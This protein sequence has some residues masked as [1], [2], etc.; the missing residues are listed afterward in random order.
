[1][2]VA[3]VLIDKQ[4]ISRNPGAIPT[5]LHQVKAG[6]D[7]FGLTTANLSVKARAYLSSLGLPDPD[8]SLSIGEA[9]WMH[10]LAIAYS[11]AYVSQNADGLRQ[12]WP[13]VPLPVSQ[14]AL[15]A[16]AE[17]GREVANL[18]D[19]EYAVAGVTTGVIRQDLV[20]VAVITRVGG[21]TL[22]SDEFSVA[23]GW[24]HAGKGGIVMPGRGKLQERVDGPTKVVD[25]YLNGHAYWK[26]VPLAAWTFTIGGYQVMKK[27]LSYRERDILGRPLNLDE[28]REVTA[29]GRRLTAL[30]ALQNQLDKNYQTT[31]AST[32]HWP[33]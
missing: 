13:R 2:V 19:T 30:V 26:G 24:G 15:L 23:A 11:P 9:L 16:S 20:G 27:W 22:K 1:M 4:M 32:Y 31:I 29:M 3:S 7:L 6:A 18:L 25:V 21:G 33:P 12:G 10:A 17:L 8:G 28:I 14:D 5:R